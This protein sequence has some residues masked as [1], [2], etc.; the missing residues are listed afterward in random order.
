VTNPDQIVIDDLIVLGRG[1]PEEIKNGRRTICTAGYS[2]KLG[3]IRIYPTRW[4]METL[5]RW[6]VVKVPVERPIRPRFNGRKESWKIIGSKREW[7]RLGEK[8]EVIGRYPRKKQPELIGKLV[9]NC[10]C[11]IQDSGRSLGIIR[12]RIIDYYFEEQDFETSIQ[13][14]L[15]GR[16]RVKVKDEFSLEPR[17]KYKCKGCRVRRGFHDQQLLEWGVYEWIRKNPNNSEQVWENLGLDNAEYEKFFFVGNMYQYPT[18]F[19]IISVLRFKKSVVKPFLRRKKGPIN[20]FF[21]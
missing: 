19:V 1:C 14:T 6:N 5:K 16:F 2:P 8:I 17:I 20:D 7:H 4:D 3:F 18:A 21:R 13:Q 12:P 10:V 9:D 15:D 11:D